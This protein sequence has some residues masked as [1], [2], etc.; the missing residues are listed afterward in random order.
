MAKLTITAVGKIVSNSVTVEVFTNSQDDM[1]D[2]ARVSNPNAPFA[3]YARVN[4]N[5]APV[6]DALVDDILETDTGVRV[7]I[8]LVDDGLTSVSADLLADDGMY[9]QVVVPPADGSYRITVTAETQSSKV[10]SVGEIAGGTRLL[11]I[12][13]DIPE[14]TQ[15]VPAPG[16]LHKEVTYGK[17]VEVVNRAQ[18]KAVSYIFF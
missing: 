4:L 11:P 3:I 7:P 9:A 8:H 10:R 18:Y 16:G 12:K 2:L 14:E 1:I 13:Q 6:L 17:R 5:G 15:P